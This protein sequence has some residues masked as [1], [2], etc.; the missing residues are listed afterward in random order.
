MFDHDDNFE[1]DSDGE[2]VLVGLTRS[3]MLEFIRLDELINAD[4]SFPGILRD[5]WHSADEK[6]WLEL[7]DKHEAARHLFLNGNK[8]RH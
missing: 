1:L 8:T 4:G 5:E 2:P 3:E 6:R 7:W